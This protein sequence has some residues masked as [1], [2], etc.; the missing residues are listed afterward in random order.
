VASSPN[1]VTSVAPAIP[2]RDEDLARGPVEDA[3]LVDG[4]CHVGDRGLA[5]AVAAD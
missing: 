2:F 1:P 4:G 3:H 5:L